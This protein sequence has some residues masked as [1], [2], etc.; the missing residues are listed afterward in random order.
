LCE[1]PEAAVRQADV[2][3][4]A[5][6]I[7]RTPKPVIAP[8]W[9]SPGAFLCTLDFDSYATPEAFDS[10]DLLSTDDV[11]QFRHYREIGYF[12]GIRTDPVDLG[13]IVASMSA[14][15][16]SESQRIVSI[17]LGL[18]A[19]DVAVAQIVYRRALEL[20]LGVELPL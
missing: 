19:E 3:V 14:R 5:G 15:R 7:L 13:C 18:A 16:T 6:P 8:E 1:T 9:L 10:A 11:P 17:N 20:R 2:V 12:S 4:T